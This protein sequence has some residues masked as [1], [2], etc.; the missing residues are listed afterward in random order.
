MYLFI[1]VGGNDSVLEWS[2]RYKIAV[3]TA[4]GV[5]YLHSGCQRRIIHR[6]IKASNILLGHEFEPQVNISP[7]KFAFRCA[8]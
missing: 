4:R 6:D 8:F 2:I 1:L 5:H 7:P 3:G